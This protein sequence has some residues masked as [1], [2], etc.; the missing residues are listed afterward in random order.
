MHLNSITA[1]VKTNLNYRFV[2]L[3]GRPKEHDRK[4]VAKDLVEWSQLE[5]SLNLNGFCAYYKLPPSYVSRWAKEDDLFRQAYELAKANLGERRERL[6]SQDLLHVKAYD[7]NANV[8]DPFLKEERREQLQ[9]EADLA[10]KV[11]ETPKNDLS[12]NDQNEAME[13]RHRLRMEIERL[14]K[15]LEDKS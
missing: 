4:Q 12:T 6:L 14:K 15:L 10:K 5:T 3:G 13:E 2:L 7:L 1:K 9:F 11:S 8:Y